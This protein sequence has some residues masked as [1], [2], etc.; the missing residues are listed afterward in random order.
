MEIISFLTLTC[1]SE[2]LKR[3]SEKDA[4]NWQ[5]FLDFMDKAS[6]FMHLANETIMPRRPRTSAH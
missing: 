3:F 1:E 2:S 6:R 4:T 5:P